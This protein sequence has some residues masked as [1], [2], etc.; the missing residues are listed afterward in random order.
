M[1]RNSTGKSA[2]RAQEASSYVLH[3]EQAS[4]FLSLL[5]RQNSLCIDHQLHQCLALS[6]QCACLV[7]GHLQSSMSC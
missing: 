3:I 7:K 2:G 1:S 4:L 6:F 5:A